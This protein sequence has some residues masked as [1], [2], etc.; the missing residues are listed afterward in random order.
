MDKQLVSGYNYNYG[1]PMNTLFNLPG[2]V[3]K[4]NKC[5]M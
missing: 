4:Q 2:K 3:F 1:A 5:I